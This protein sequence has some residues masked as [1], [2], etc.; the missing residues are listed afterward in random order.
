MLSAGNEDCQ[1]LLVP[2]Q[3][4]PKARWRLYGRV[5]WGEAWLLGRRR[6]QAAIEDCNHFGV[7]KDERRRLTLR[8]NL[9]PSTATM[10]R[11]S[12]SDACPYAY[13]ARHRLRAMYLTSYRLSACLYFFDRADQFP[14]RIPIADSCNATPECGSRFA[15]RS[16]KCT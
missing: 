14:L 16:C 7:R 1:G 15:L 6:V 10:V 11:A 3:S 8:V 4:S 2:R 13:T 12:A 9:G 5:S